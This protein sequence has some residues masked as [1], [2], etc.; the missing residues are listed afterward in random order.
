[1]NGLEKGVEEARE[2]GAVGDASSTEQVRKAENDD[3]KM[4]EADGKDFEDGR[5]LFRVE[6]Y[7]G[8]E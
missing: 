7:V 5:R 3:V 8:E 1:M 6:L 2:D 4:A